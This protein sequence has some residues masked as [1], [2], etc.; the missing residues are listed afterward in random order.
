MKKFVVAAVSVLT[1]AWG[2]AQK[3]AAYFNNSFQTM[4]KGKDVELMDR[5]KTNQVGQ[6][7]MEDN[8]LQ[9]IN[10]DDAVKIGQKAGADYVLF[11]A[12]TLNGLRAGTMFSPSPTMTGTASIRLINVKDGQLK[13]MESQNFDGKKSEI[14]DAYT[15]VEHKFT[16]DLR[17]Y[18]F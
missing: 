5:N 1:M 16:R 12:Y 7:Y 9:D 15:T 6:I 11:V 3:T 14:R 4:F 2:N 8:R 18:T 13:I 17:T 10:N